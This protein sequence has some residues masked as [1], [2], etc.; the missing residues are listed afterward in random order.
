MVE[1]MVWGR[2]KLEPA[3]AELRVGPGVP[4]VDRSR[5]RII[6]CLARQGGRIG[7]STKRCRAWRRE[8]A[9]EVPLKP[10]NH[11]GGWT[12]LAEGSQIGFGKPPLELIRP[13]HWLAL[14]E[15]YAS[16]TKG[17][18]TST[19]ATSERRLRPARLLELADG[20]RQSSSRLGVSGWNELRLLSRWMA[21][22]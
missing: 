20:V 12:T 21:T 14:P 3:V 10:V 9:A 16:R 19:A 1:P 17:T 13:A 6:L 22:P 5:L 4:L 11:S 18:S 7:M 15:L 8:V 2:T